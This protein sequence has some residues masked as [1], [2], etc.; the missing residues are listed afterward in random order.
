MR[1]RKRAEDR[2]PS[3]EEMRAGFNPSIEVAVEEV[4]QNL[5]GP[6][7]SVEQLRELYNLTDPSP[8]L[9]DKAEEK[10]SE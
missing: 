7:P 6:V 2:V 4:R 5:K 10:A 8:Y 9:K 1:R 3:I